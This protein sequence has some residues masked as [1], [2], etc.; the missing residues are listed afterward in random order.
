MM[1]SNFSQSSSDPFFYRKPRGAKTD[2][3]KVPH[4]TLKGI[5]DSQAECLKEFLAQD[6]EKY[7]ISFYKNQHGYLSVGGKKDHGITKF[8]ESKGVK[9]RRHAI[10][11]FEDTFKFYGFDAHYDPFDDSLNVTSRALKE[12]ISGGITDDPKAI[13]SPTGDGTDISLLKIHPFQNLEL[14]KSQQGQSR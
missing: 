14:W 13:F 9:M 12:D 1:H 4:H 10:P 3:D 2:S 8:L 7:G 5:S 11:V 6:G